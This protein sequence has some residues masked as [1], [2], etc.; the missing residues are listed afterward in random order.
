MDR[1]PGDPGREPLQLVPDAALRRQRAGRRGR[2]TRP[3]R[4][5]CSG[6]TRPATTPSG[7]GAAPAE[8]DRHASSRSPR[9]RARPCSSASRGR[10]RRSR[11]ASP[12]SASTP[13]AR[14]PRC[15]AARPAGPLNAVTT[16]LPADGGRY[17][18]VVRQEAGPPQPLDLFSETVGFGAAAV[19]D[20]SIPTP[21]DAARRAD[22][23]RGEVDR[24]V[25]RALLLAGAVGRGREARPRRPDLRD[26]QPRVARHGGH[27]GRDG[28]RRRAP[29][30]CCA[31]GG[32]PRGCRPARPTCGP[33]SRA[34]RSTWACPG[35]TRSTAPA[36]RASTRTR[37]A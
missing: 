15:S 21:G 9:R 14:G 33:R 34:A 2:W 12:W 18:L 6:S 36:W 23:G 37:R 29:P 20:G 10:R 13:R 8:R 3:P 5:A 22:R 4:P 30:C 17:R 27:V 19:P 31:S 11:R 35:P 26:L 25:A 1:R 16:P 24:H 7:T 32:W 28:A